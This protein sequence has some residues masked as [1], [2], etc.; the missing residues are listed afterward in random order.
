MEGLEM[1]CFKIIAGVGAARSCFIE[2]MQIARKGD[3][4]KAEQLIQD[5][6]KEFVNAHQAH[7][8]LITNEANGNK[9]DVTL[10]LLHAEDQIMSAETIKIMALKMI[11]MCRQFNK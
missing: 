7:A 9:T 2:A 8:E 1:I 10:L 11:E 4:E 6:E 5:G 3:Y